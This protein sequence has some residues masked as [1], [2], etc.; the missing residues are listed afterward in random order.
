MTEQNGI[1]ILC[2]AAGSDLLLGSMF[3]ESSP[4]QPQPPQQQ[5][6][7]QQ[8]QQPS[9]RVKL[10]HATSLSAPSHVCH[11]CRRVY[12]RADH[13]TRHLRSHENARPYQCSRC[14]K[15]FNRADLLTRHETTHDRE[16]DGKGRPIIRRSDRAAEACQNCASSKAKCDDQKPCGRCKSKNLDCQIS[17]K[18]SSTYRTSID[19]QSTVSSSDYSPKQVSV[20]FDSNGTVEHSMDRRI[21]LAESEQLPTAD[22]HG[23]EAPY[24]NDNFVPPAPM[25]DGIADGMVYFNPTHNFFQDMDF[26][27]WDLNFDGFTIPQFEISGPSPQSS[28]ASA[29]RLHRIARDP[30]R[31]HAAFKRS[32]WLWEPK[33][34]DYVV[35]DKEALTLDE[36]TIAQSPAYEKMVAINSHRLKMEPTHRDRMFAMVLAQNKD[37]LKVPSFPSLDLLNYLLQTHFVQDEYQTDSWIHLASFNPS[38]AMPELLA[39]VIA[40]GA[41]FIAVPAVWQFGLALQ[42]V[43][44]IGMSN[45]FES[46][47]SFTRDLQSLQAFMLVLD[48]GIWSGFKRKMEIAESFVQPVMTMLRR[49]GTFSAPADS[50][51]L[52]PLAT[53]TPE[54]LNAKWRG[55]IERESYKRLVIHIFIHDTQSSVSLQKNPLM[56]Y[57]EL[58]FSLP[59]SRALWKAPTA[60]VW[61]DR[62]LQK[63]TL[64]PG[65]DLPRVSEVMYCMETLEAYAECVDVELCQTAVLYGFWGQVAAYREAVKFYHHAINRRNNTHRLWLTTQHQELYRDLGEYLTL[66]CS[67]LPQAAAPHLTVVTELFMMTLH[68]SPDE[69]QCFAG[70]AG[71]EE[72]RRAAVRLE[73][74]WAGSREA[75]HAVWHAGQVLRSARQLPPASLR[76]FNAIAVYFASLTLWV[77]GLLSCP[78]SSAAASA[79]QQQQQQQQ[80]GQDGGGTPEATC[81]RMDG[82]EDRETRAFLQ[83]DRGIPGIGVGVGCLTGTG[84]GDETAAAAAASTAVVVEPLARPGRVLSIARGLLRDNYYPTVVASA[85]SSS[86]S[87]SISPK[88]EPL[89]PLVESLSNLLRDLGS[90]GGA[91]AGTGGASRVPS[92][93]T[94]EDRL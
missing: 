29:S 76:G 82:H 31:G 13:L 24:F 84:T 33:S 59:A 43:V 9:K 63:R 41:T 94:S 54:A 7:H 49:A 6:Q 53:D 45:R 58:R 55:F 27:S 38:K 60:E 87:S 77:Y 67:A 91:G 5:Q 15:R 44:R 47:N 18:R 40:C 62:Y 10:S 78:K 3:G 72:A 88:G 25:M 79:G 89:P 20:G 66:L 21:S 42:E 46:S 92:R 51:S 86:Y 75:R 22:H 39:A 71:E 35:R 74:E 68:V 19:G 8:P 32:P 2:D 52:I 80:Q 93:G 14:P 4:Q 30:S 81:V 12:E 90:S 61:R 69:L 57:T 65:T 37:P 50:P 1:D 34:K 17:T 85:S 26:T 48:V 70:K 28:T 36:D 11:I 64:P 56:S 23:V 16:G 83:L 73:D